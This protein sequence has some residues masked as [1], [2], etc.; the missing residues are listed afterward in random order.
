[1][2]KSTAVPARWVPFLSV[3]GRVSPLD[4]REHLLAGLPVTITGATLAAYLEAAY[5][6]GQK[7]GA[8]DTAHA[9]SLL[10]QKVTE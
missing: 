10:I 2:T 9:M 5:R 6:S 4:A 3:E 1:M 8:R 7:K